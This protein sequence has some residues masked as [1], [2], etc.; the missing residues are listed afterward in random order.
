M[1]FSCFKW[2][3]QFI[4]AKPSKHLICHFI[5][6]TDV[7]DE[8]PHFSISSYDQESTRIIQ[9]KFKVSFKDRKLCQQI[10]FVRTFEKCWGQFLSHFLIGSI[11]N[12]IVYF[13]GRT[14]L[15]WHTSKSSSILP[16]AKDLIFFLAFSFFSIPLVL[17]NSLDIRQF[18]FMHTRNSHSKSLE[19]V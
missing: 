15:L 4:K 7:L 9:L 13:L 6:D 5:E 18:H 11:L 1:H 3:Y 12:S 10:I 2:R 14:H 8:C 16:C 19:T 17:P